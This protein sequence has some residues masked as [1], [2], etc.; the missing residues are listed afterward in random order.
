MDERRVAHPAGYDRLFH[1]AQFAFKFH[2]ATVALRPGVDP[3]AVAHRLTDKAAAITGGKA[4]PFE[5]TP[6]PSILQAVKDVAVLPLVLSVF[7]AVLAV[8]AVGH[9]LSIEQYERETTTSPPATR[10]LRIV[11]FYMPVSGRAVT[12][13]D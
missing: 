7:L 3:Q 13:Q 6:P 5:V 12:S 11:E 4:F 2:V 8:G 1:G 9:A 10:N